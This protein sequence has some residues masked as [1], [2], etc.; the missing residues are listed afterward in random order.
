M[1]VCIYICIR[2]ILKDIKLRINNTKLLNAN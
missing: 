1:Y 2:I